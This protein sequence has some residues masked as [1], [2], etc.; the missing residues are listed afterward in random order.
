MKSNTFLIVFFSLLSSS[1]S[2]DEDIIAKVICSFETTSADILSIE[3]TKSIN[4]SKMIS[5]ECNLKVKIFTEAKENKNFFVAFSNLNNNK[6]IMELVKKDGKHPINHGLI[7]FDNFNVIVN[8]SSRINQDVKFIDKKTWMVYEY[9]TINGNDIMRSIGF[10]NTSSFQYESILLDSLI[11]RRN[12]LQGYKLKAMTENYLNDIKIDMATAIYDNKTQMYDVT[13]ST[14]GRYFE[15]FL[16]MQ[17]HLNFTASLHKN[18]VAWGE[19]SMLE[20]DT[21]F[22]SGIFKSVHS[23]PAEVIMTE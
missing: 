2:I 4:L 3:R 16:V 8:L 20:N 9:Y 23:G 6:R 1:L 19:V 17:D 7:F 11:K 22:I 5:K 18:I 10:F 12:N 13:Q 21:L 15:L 14:N